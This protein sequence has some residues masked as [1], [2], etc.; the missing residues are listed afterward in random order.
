MRTYVI[1]YGA[2]QNKLLQIFCIVEQAREQG[3]VQNN[4]P[5]TTSKYGAFNSL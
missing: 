1:I 4:V 2:L 5:N 3:P